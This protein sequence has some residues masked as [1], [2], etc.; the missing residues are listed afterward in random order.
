M[1][2]PRPCVLYQYIVH[3]R[4]SLSS[5][6]ANPSSQSLLIGVN[7]SD[8]KASS[9]NSNNQHDALPLSLCVVSIHCPV[10]TVLVIAEC[11]SIVSIAS[12][13]QQHERG[14]SNPTDAPRTTATKST[15][16]PTTDSLPMSTAQL[17]DQV[18]PA[19]RQ[20]PVQPE[21][22]DH[23][24]AS[25]HCRRPEGRISTRIRKTVEKIGRVGSWQFVTP[26]D[27][28]S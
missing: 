2:C 25:L 7:T 19:A 18:L 11:K 20:S 8:P 9:P 10:T 21:L 4:P 28:I 26:R 22:I 17:H 15:K 14:I 6:N 16:L 23:G 3:L 5:R 27:K 24:H 13:R 1:R 12:H